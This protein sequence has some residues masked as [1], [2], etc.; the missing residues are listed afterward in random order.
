MYGFTV[1]W[2]YIFFLLSCSG[3]LSQEKN[4]CEFRGFVDICKKFSPRNLGAWHF[5]AG[6]GNNLRKGNL[7]FHKFAK[8][9]SRKSFSLYTI[10]RSPVPYLRVFRVHRRIWITASGTELVFKDGD[11]AW[12]IIHVAMVHVSLAPFLEVLRYCT[13]NVVIYLNYTMENCW[14]RAMCSLFPSLSF[15]WSGLVTVPLAWWRKRRC[16][17]WRR[18]SSTARRTKRTRSCQ[19]DYKKLSERL[20]RHRGSRLRLMVLF[21]SFPLS[22]CW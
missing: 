15:G 6:P 21:P 14:Q 16:V 20:L 9:S 8:V 2:T 3:K 11:H 22:R 4:L 10:C 19:N 18:A 12:C 17:L 1:C 5:L 13:S 7:I